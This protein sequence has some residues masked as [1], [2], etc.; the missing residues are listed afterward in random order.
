MFNLSP[1]FFPAQDNDNEL[2]NNPH[3]GIIISNQSLVLQN[4]TRLRMGAYTC[5]ASNS[6]GS[7]ES[8]P[9]QLNVLCEFL[10]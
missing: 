9:V 8:Q 3:D 5:I 2:Q 10:N 6:E 7:G 4:V 1:F